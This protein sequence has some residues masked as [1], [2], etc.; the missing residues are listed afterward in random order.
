M[1]QAADALLVLLGEVIVRLLPFAVLIAE[2]RFEGM[3]DGCFALLD[4][5]TNFDLRLRQAF[6]L[7]F[8]QVGLNRVGAAKPP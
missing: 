5:R 8:E 4:G 6:G 1:R 3:I 7:N 2:R